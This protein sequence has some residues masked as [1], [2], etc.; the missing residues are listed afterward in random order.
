MKVISRKIITKGPQNHQ[1][2]VG[3]NARI[4]CVISQASSE[5]TKVSW[6]K[7]NNDVDMD[8]SGRFDVDPKTNELQIQ[9]AKIE[10]SGKYNS[11]RVM[12]LN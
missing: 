3:C 8:N 9:D 10:D 7:D 1:V 5:Y 11:S 2:C 4:D 6:K 12:E